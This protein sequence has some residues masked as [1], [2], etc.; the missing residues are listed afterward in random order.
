MHIVYKS[1]AHRD[2]MMQLPFAQGLNMA[3]DRLQDIAGK[4]K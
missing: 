1:I 4:L 3:H 2:Q